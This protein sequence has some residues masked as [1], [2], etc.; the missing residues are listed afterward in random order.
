MNL[1]AT[2][3]LINEYFDKMPSRSSVSFRDLAEV[4]ISMRPGDEEARHRVVLGVEHVI[5]QVREDIT[6]T[7]GTCQKT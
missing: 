5:A 3:R 4:I 1:L 2:E 6:V 7:G